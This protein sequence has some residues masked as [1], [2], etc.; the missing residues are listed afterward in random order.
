MIDMSFRA[1]NIVN[2]LGDLWHPH[3]PIDVRQATNDEAD[4]F[5]RQLLNLTAAEVLEEESQHWDGYTRRNLLSRAAS[6]RALG[7][8]LPTGADV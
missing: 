2:Q 5:V 8:A 6:F 1:L 7:P 4:E 3:V